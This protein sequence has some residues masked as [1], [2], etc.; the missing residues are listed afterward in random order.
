MQDQD[1]EK[2]DFILH[3]EQGGYQAHRRRGEEACDEC[4]R[5][6][7]EYM[8]RYR[9]G[10]VEPREISRAEKQRQALSHGE[11]RAQAVAD[12]RN[13]T[14]KV[15]PEDC[16]AYPPFLKARGAN[17][18][19]EVVTTYT[20]T[21]PALDILRT[22]CEQL[23]QLERLNAALSSGKTAWFELGDPDDEGIPIVVN[24]MLSEHRQTSASIAKLMRDLGL[25]EKAAPKEG[26]GNALAEFTA[27]IAK[28]EK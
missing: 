27:E 7:R 28:E 9:D 1:L 5:A 10:E 24:A 13:G 23:D 8:R 21:E 15:L 12:K 4:K 25:M 22:I 3:G 18:W 14:R 26:A 11:D 20:L 2:P 17:F 6:H 16:P 19:H